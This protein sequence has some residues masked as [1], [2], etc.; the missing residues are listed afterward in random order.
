MDFS[1]IATAIASLKSAQELATATLAVRD[2]NQSAAAIAQINEKLLAAQQGLLA[3]NTMLLQLQSDYV[4]TT[5]EL[6]ELKEAATQKAAYTLFDIGGGVFVYRKKSEPGDGGA[7][8]TTSQ[9]PEHYVCQPCFDGGKK[10]VLQHWG[11]DWRCSLCTEI[12]YRR[13]DY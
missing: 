5:R 13:V 7:V 8:A 10:S 11:D 12:Y 4:D 6:R 2:F 3:H 9:E 1:S